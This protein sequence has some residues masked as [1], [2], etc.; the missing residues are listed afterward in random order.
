[1]LYSSLLTVPVSREGNS[2]G[3]WL[4]GMENSLPRHFGT[5]N[6]YLTKKV[7]ECRVNRLTADKERRKNINGQLSITKKMSKSNI[8]THIE[9]KDLP[10]SY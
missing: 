9:R 1:M 5:V 10:Q 4:L 3:S 6:Y 8:L 2:L 7:F